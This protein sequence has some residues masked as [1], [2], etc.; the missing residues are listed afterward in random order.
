MLDRAQEPAR[1]REREPGPIL[2][3]TNLRRGT[4]LFVLLSAAGL[5]GVFLWKRP[6]SPAFHWR[7]LH[8]IPLLAVV[9]L[10]CVDYLLGGGRFRIYFNGRLFTHISLWQCVRS[11]WANMFTAALTP[12]Q[13]GGL[14]GKT[15]VLWKN[16]ARV[17]EVSLAAVLNLMATISVFGTFAAAAYFFY[18]ER[19]YPGNLNHVIHTAFI[20]LA[21]LFLAILLGLILPGPLIR[22]VA[23]AYRWLPLRADRK[24]RLL[25][26]TSRGIMR[27]HRDFIRVGL[28]FKGTLAL[29]YFF[30]ALMYL[31]KYLIG[32]LLAR[33]L[34]YRPPFA[35]FFAVQVLQVLIVYFGFTPGSSGIAEITTAAMMS[36]FIP[37]RSLAIYTLLWRILITYLG[38]GL[39]AWTLFRE[40]RRPARGRHRSEDG[41]FRPGIHPEAGFRTR[42]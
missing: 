25:Y 40:L 18:P 26:R 34:G 4:V 12:A 36:P 3:G 6:S 27:V 28:D 22:A 41:G 20:G 24:R 33:A 8:P 21:V 2:T 29:T 31:N 14:I 39:G 42:S 13:S 5:A 10:L 1:D 7:N 15:F 30:N 37:A 23:F 32:Y 9:P 17:A 16:G 35:A 38:V 11:N 19:L